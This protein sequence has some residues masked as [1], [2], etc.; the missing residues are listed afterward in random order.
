ML[1]STAEPTLLARVTQLI[2]SL[3]GQPLMRNSGASST[4]RGFGGVV[5]LAPPLEVPR[6]SEMGWFGGV[7][8]AS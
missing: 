7:M 5:K 4:G 1:K 6:D 8:A 2:G 3:V